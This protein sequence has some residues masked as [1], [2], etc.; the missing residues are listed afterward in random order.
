MKMKMKI[1]YINLN[2][3]VDAH[4][5]LLQ[6]MQEWEVGLGIITEPYKVEVNSEWISDDGNSVAIVR[7]GNIETGKQGK[8][9]YNCPLGRPKC[10][11]CVCLA[12]PAVGL[13]FSPNGS[14][15]R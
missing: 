6:T 7:N 13:V 15:R 12:Q 2:H 10:H 4:D 5:L 9:V 11:W 14:D 3:S 8:W 1:L